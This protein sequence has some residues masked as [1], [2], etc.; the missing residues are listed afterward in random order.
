MGS[1]LLAYIAGLVTILSPCVL[2]LLPVVLGSALNAHRRGPQALAL[3]LVL[4]FTGFGLLIATVGFS[5]GLTP[6]VFSKVAAA[7]MIAFGLVLMSSSL[8]VRF[9]MAAEAATSGLSRQ[10]EAYSP[11]GLRGQFLLG[12]LLGAVWTPC[13]GPTLGA[14]IAVAAQGTDLGYAAVIMFVF[15]LGTVTPL[16]ALMFGAREAIARRKEAMARL[17]QWI[18]PV[19]GG[20]LV[21]VGLAILTGLMTEWEAFLL[22]LTPLWLIQFIYQF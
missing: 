3:G 11:Q 9:A 12:V 10:T 1:V 15:A 13:V 22:E 6:A 7:M 14:A 19:L 2:P 5:L 16:L 8:Q 4:S 20:L 17:N 18:K 21:A